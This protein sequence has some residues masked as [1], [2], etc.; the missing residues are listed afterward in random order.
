ME[1]YRDVESYVR[2]GL[3][4]P[5]EDQRAPLIIVSIDP[6]YIGKNAMKFYRFRTDNAVIGICQPENLYEH[7]QLMKRV[8]NKDGKVVLFT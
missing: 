7:M 6:I 2:A 4:F 8:Y 1:D 5:K 3:I